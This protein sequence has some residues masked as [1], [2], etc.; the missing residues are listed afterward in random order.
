MGALVAQRVAGLDNAF[1]AA[2]AGTD[3]QAGGDLVFV[4][5]RMTVRVRASISRSIKAEKPSGH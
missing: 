3:Q 1:D 2:N 4:R 5:F